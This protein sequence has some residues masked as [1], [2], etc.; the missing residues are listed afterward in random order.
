MMVLGVDPGLSGSFCLFD[1][2]ENVEFF[3]M[4]TIVVSKEKRVDF[5]KVLLWLEGV[6]KRYGVIPAY[7]ERAKPMAMGSKFAFNYG[8]DFEKVVLAIHLAGFKKRLK[9]VDPSIWTKEMHDGIDR[10]IKS[11]AKSLIALND[12]YPLMVAHVPRRP[13]GALHDGPVDAFLIA[14]FG[15]RCIALE[16]QGF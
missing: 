9:Q 5:G 13:K 15:H 1:G 8:R 6:K 16:Q 4:P 7:L 3:M 11:K 10:D 12:L 2:G 14:A